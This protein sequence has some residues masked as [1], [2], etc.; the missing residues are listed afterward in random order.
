M[1]NKQDA[2]DL[3]NEVEGLNE[4]DEENTL[5]IERILSKVARGEYES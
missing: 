4:T 5:K 3:L 2:Q 1:E